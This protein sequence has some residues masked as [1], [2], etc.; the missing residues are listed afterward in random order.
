MNRLFTIHPKARQEVL[1]A[2]TYLETQK[3]GY[4][5]L[6]NLRVDEAISRIL[7][8]PTRYQE[9]SKGRGRYRLALGKPFHKSYSIYYDYDGE[10]VRIIAVFHHRRDGSI[11]QERK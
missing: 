1:D 5:D 3:E 2:I 7:E 6:F 11:W 10:I 8:H 9:V 4:G